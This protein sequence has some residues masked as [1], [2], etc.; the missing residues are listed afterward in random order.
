[1]GSN[2]NR[3]MWYSLATMSILILAVFWAVMPTMS[4]VP[5]QATSGSANSGRSVQKDPKN[6]Q[7]PSTTSKPSN[8]TN[9]AP[10]RNSTGK[11]EATE[12]SNTYVIQ[13]SRDNQHAWIFDFLLVAVGVGQAV[14]LYMQVRLMR[15]HAGHLEK[16][17]TAA[18]DNAKAAQ[19]NTQALEIANIQSAG[20]FKVQNRPW[21]GMSKELVLS[22]KKSTKLGQFGFT[23]K[24]AVKNFGTEPAF[25]TVV[26][27]VDSVDDANNRDLVKTKITE[28]RQIGENIVHLTGDLLLPTAEKYNTHSFG[29]RTRPDKF[30]IPGCI[31]YRFADGTIHYTELSY[32]IDLSEG[33]KATFRTLWFQDAN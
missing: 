7:T 21:V 16:L 3:I 17:A 29:E 27:L 2:L 32:W 4:P 22:E 24:Y 11:N 26:V 8:D 30:A 14:V 10:G 31:V 33:E 5:R 18:S 20:F 1:V 6:N 9:P 23:L 28:A 19:S 25:H 13:P 12:Q 15:T